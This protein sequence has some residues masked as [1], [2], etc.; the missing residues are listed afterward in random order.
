MKIKVA[1][2]TLLI[3]QYRNIPSIA[4]TLVTP[5]LLRHNNNFNV[6][7]TAVKDIMLIIMLMEGSILHQNTVSCWHS[8]VRKGAINRHHLSVQQ[9]DVCFW[10]PPFERSNVDLSVSIALITV[11]L[12][13]RSSLLK[14]WYFRICQS[15]SLNFNR[16]FEGC[17]FVIAGWT[18]PISLRERIQ[19]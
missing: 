10:W 7:Q 12:G 16:F 18:G 19:V 5:I 1:A 13:L 6:L 2:L 11:W 9:D 15:Y 14:G 4:M 3:W 8:N 17:D